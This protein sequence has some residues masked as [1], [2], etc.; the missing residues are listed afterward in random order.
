VHKSGGIVEPGVAFAARNHPQ[1]YGEVA[2][3]EINSVRGIS[4][5]FF[6]A[7]GVEE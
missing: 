4:G 1:R 5:F 6:L 7:V 2:M 3:R